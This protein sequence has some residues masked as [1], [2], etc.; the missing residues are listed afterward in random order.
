MEHVR[1]IGIALGI[2]SAVLSAHIAMTLSFR[3]AEACY[4][5]LSSTKLL[6]MDIK[7]LI[8]QGE[9]QSLEFKS[10]QVHPDSLAKEMVAFANSAGGL[11]LLGVA[12]DGL[13]SG[14]PV[15]DKNFEEW[16]TNIARQNVVP[17]LDVGIEIIQ[18]DSKIVLV[19]DV[20]KGSEK[21]YQTRQNQF[22]IRIGS[23]N[24]TAT[25]GESQNR[26]AHLQ[27]R[28]PRI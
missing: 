12:D 17:G 23:T 27:P 10:A 16:V 22:L 15:D 20:P 2:I 7:A 11:I 1:L 25:Q 18:Q 6:N 3:Y 28:R 21:P 4:Y 9:N 14:L 13:I 24:R 26:T 5:H 19:I 8:A